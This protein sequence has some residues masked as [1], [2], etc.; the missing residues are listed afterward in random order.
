MHQQ[1]HLKKL[2][3][4]MDHAVIVA[5]RVRAAFLTELFGGH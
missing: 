4:D 5:R 1:G 3:H 2:F